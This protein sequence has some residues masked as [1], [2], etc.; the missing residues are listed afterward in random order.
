MLGVYLSMPLL[1]EVYFN[2]KERLETL[3][4]ELDMIAE[5][6]KR[7]RYIQAKAKVI[8]DL[9]ADI[10]RAI[11]TIYQYQNFEKSEALISN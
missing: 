4:V 11:K 2:E 7:S 5:I 10:P 1:Q 3:L 6:K 8:A 9:L